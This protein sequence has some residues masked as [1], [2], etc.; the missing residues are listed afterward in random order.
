[1]GAPGVVLTFTGERLIVEADGSAK[2]GADDWQ[3]PQPYKW[4]VE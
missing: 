1:L 3:G 2:W 4:G